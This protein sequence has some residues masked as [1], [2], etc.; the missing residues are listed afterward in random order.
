MN[1]EIDG[2]TH[3]QT[4]KKQ[5]EMRRHR[6]TVEWTD[7][8]LDSIVGVLYI[9]FGGEGAGRSKIHNLGQTQMLKDKHYSS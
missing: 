7:G 6:Q 4:E 9:F 2:W 8:L 3:E 1:L 5:M